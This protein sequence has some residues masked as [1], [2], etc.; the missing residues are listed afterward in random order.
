MGE[1]SVTILGC[2]SA[3]P[4]TRH[5]PSC[6][7]VNHNGNLFMIDCGEGS[8]LQFHRCRLNFQRLSHVFI[9]HMHGDH[10]LGLPGML[11]T[12]SMQRK[13]G[14]VTVHVL[15]EGIDILS[16]M[17]DYFCGEAGFEIRFEPIPKEGGVVYADD[18]LTVKAFPLDHLFPCVGFLFEEK[19]KARHLLG[20]VADR[21]GIPAKNRKEIV[22]G[23]DYVLPDGSIVENSRLTSPPDSSASYAYCSDTRYMPSLAETL[24]GV[25]TIYHEAT[26]DDEKVEKADGRGHS[27]AGQAAATARDASAK[28]LILGHFSKSYYGENLHRSQAE[29]VFKGEIIVAQEGM[30]IDLS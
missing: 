8:Q 22:A 4:S 28:R 27:T 14:R 12:F 29:A 16:R 3:S 10:V 5:L 23:A 20:D 1:F 2:G 13:T 25:G 24:R 11:S 19:P 15:E 6:Q 30:V 17:T 7:V 26:Y 21:L 9:S 18:K